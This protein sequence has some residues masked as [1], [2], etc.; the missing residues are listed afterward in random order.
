MKKTLLSIIILIF[1]SLPI[2][3][4]S[5][6]QVTYEEKTYS[7]TNPYNS[8]EIDTHNTKVEIVNSKDNLTTINYVDSNIDNYDISVFDN[9]LSI[10]LKQHSDINNYFGVK[11]SSKRV[12]KLSLPN[13]IDINDLNIVTTNK[14]ISYS[15]DNNVNNASINNTS[16]KILVDE[17][18]IINS[19]TLFCKDDDITAN[20]IGKYE[21][22]KIDIEQK[23]GESNLASKDYGDKTLK[24]TSNNGNIDIKFI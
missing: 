3:L 13:T 23:K 9:K 12:L 8:I 2:F 11:D 15:L 18:N 6:S 20:I 16:G 10:I 4:S 21:D 5:C 1:C 7:V 24:I 22:Y 17:I 14:E 19:F